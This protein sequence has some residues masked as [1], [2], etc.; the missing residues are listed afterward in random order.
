VTDVAVTQMAPVG[1]EAPAAPTVEV[2]AGVEVQALVEH[3]ERVI[4]ALRQQLEVALREAE[5]AEQRVAS[6][7]A[8]ALVGH[9]RSDPTAQ[10]AVTA[11]AD[12]AAGAGPRTTVVSR[13]RATPAAAQGSG[14]GPASG[15]QHS[16]SGSGLFRSHLVM[17][18][19]VLIAL[20]AVLLLLFA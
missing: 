1:P 4:R 5:E 6:H 7:P 14:A 9:D 20:L 11:P 16:A 17:K 2:V 18:L 3:S 19:G 8:A 15:Y 13:P 10:I 12:G